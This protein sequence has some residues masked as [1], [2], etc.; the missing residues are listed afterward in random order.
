MPPVYVQLV[1]FFMALIL[2]CILSPSNPICLI[3]RERYFLPYSWEFGVSVVDALP[4]FN[5]R[6]GFGDNPSSCS[7]ICLLKIILMDD[8]LIYSPPFWQSLCF[9]SSGNGARH[10]WSTSGTWWTLR[11]NSSSFKSGLSSRSDALIGD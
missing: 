4:V 2:L 6:R 11:R 5:L 3:T 9:W 7:N 1:F 8:L 10:G